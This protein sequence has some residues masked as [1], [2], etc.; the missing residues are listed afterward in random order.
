MIADAG[1]ILLLAGVAMLAFG[2]LRGL[3]RLRLVSTGVMLTGCL[4]VT[5]ELVIAARY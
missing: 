4:V 1:R 5:C 2:E 3:W